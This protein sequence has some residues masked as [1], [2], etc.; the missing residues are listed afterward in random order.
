[1]RKRKE[2]FFTIGYLGGMDTATI[3]IHLKVEEVLEK[4]PGTFS[5]FMKNKTKC[6]GCFMQHFCTLK[7]VA[8]T[9][10]VSPDKLLKEIESVANSEHTQRSTL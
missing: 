7:D 6:P 10:Q 2:G 8:E 1:L 5:V 3:H 9:Y 4:W